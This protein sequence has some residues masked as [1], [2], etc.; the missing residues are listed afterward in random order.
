MEGQIA[1]QQ[2]NGTEVVRVGPP[3][4]DGRG[5]PFPFSPRW[6]TVVCK[7]AR[8]IGAVCVIVGD[9]RLG[10][11][12]VAGSRAARVPVITDLAE[13]FPEAT[14]LWARADSRLRRWARSGA[15]VRWLERLVVRLADHV[16]VVTEERRE[17]VIRQYG[18]PGTGVSVVS[19][20]PDELLSDE[21]VAAAAAR[22]AQQTPDPLVLMY[23]GVLTEDRGLEAVLDALRV[24]N[25]D[26]ARGFRLVIVGEGRHRVRLAERASDLVQD[27]RCEFS[28]WRSG[29]QLVQAMLLADIGVIPHWITGFT[30]TTIPNKLFDYMNC[31]LPVIASAMAPVHRILAETGAGRTYDGSV[32]DLITVLRSMRDPGLRLTLARNGRL[33]VCQR[34]N[35]SRDGSEVVRL[36][37]SLVRGRKRVTRT[38]A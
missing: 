7:V 28:G 9:L 22:R 30:H 26:P 33:G 10:L 37:M 25:R 23:A 11:P 14:K 24:V 3:L 36:V 16:Q 31:G 12:G 18:V 27:G 8:D 4:P 19:N 21:C 32:E 34:Y 20:T 15:H 5:R 6:A 38:S 13:N 2:V 17:E 35:W 29:Q 1:H